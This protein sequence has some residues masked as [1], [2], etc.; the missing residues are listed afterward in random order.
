LKLLNNLN[1]EALS[2]PQLQR[3]APAPPVRLPMKQ[4]PV[5]PARTRLLPARENIS[6]LAI[7][8]KSL[9]CRL[10]GK[11]FGEWNWMEEAFTIYDGNGSEAR[12]MLTAGTRTRD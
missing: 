4:H 8:R 12:N 7:D 2:L 3:S 1:L 5:F 6:P 9:L 10:C 11:I